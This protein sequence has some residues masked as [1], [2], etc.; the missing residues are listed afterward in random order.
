MG[1]TVWQFN[2]RVDFLLSRP[3][4]PSPHN[5]SVYVAKLL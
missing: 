1:L 5:P 4:L 3:N 2:G